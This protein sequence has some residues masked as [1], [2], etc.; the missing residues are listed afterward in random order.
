MNTSSSMS[1]NQVIWA[2][3]LDEEKK[4]PKYPKKKKNFSLCSRPKKINISKLLPDKDLG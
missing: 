4:D 3:F 1:D 2:M